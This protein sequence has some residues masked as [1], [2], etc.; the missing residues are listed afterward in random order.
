MFF[1][2]DSM[3]TLNAL[4]RDYRED[5]EFTQQDIANYLEIG[6]TMYRR[7]ELGETEIPLR[8]LKKL[9]MLYKVSADY[10]IGLPKGLKWGR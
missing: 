9:C 7:Y 8:H 6:R 1:M 3:K 5:N 2:G 4:L 10:L